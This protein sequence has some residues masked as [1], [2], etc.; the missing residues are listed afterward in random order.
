MSKR[1][2]HTCMIRSND[3]FIIIYIIKT[4]LNVSGRI[5]IRR[6]L[7]TVSVQ[8]NNKSINQKTSKTSTTNSQLSLPL[9]V[10]LLYVLVQLMISTA[11]LGWASTG[12]VTGGLVTTS[13]RSSV[14]LKMVV[15][16]G[17]GGGGVVGSGSGGSRLVVSL[18]LYIVCGGSG[19]GVPIHITMEMFTTNVDC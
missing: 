2:N 16:V 15:C 6:Y 18:W 10:Q 1:Y 9:L 13:T 5:Y 17:S 7:Q 4:T 14:W 8:Y 19:G 11:L 12:R 3:I